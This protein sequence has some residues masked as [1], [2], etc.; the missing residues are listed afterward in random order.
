ME[1]K[2][3]MYDVSIVEGKG[4][5]VQLGLSKV[6][7]AKIHLYTQ[8]VY[9]IFIYI[10]RPLFMHRIDFLKIYGKVAPNID[11]PKK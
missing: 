4:F 1:V 10:G 8:I 7:S 9:L 2:F 11:L 5:N 6:D 3:N